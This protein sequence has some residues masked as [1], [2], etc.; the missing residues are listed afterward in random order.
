VS[1]VS[2]DI[3]L[4]RGKVLLQGYRDHSTK[5]FFHLGLMMVFVVRL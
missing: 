1:L 5:G 2:R 3:C 4:L